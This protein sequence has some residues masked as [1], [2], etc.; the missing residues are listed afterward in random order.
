[1]TVDNDDAKAAILSALLRQLHEHE[2]FGAQFR[3]KTPKLL[4]GVDA[5]RLVRLSLKYGVLPAAAVAATGGAAAIPGAILAAAGLSQYLAVDRNAAE[6]TPK[7]QTLADVAA[8][9]KGQTPDE[10]IDVR[11]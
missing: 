4:R 10:T 6:E 9:W 1:M 5:M 11:V 7:D 3:K 8:A 2:R